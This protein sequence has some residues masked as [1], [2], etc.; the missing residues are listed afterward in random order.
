MSELRRRLRVVDPNLK[1]IPGGSRRHQHRANKEDWENASGVICRNCNREVFR[2]R[3]G[4][5]MSCWE[6]ENE[7][8]VRDK[9]GITSWLPMDIL[10]QITHP[11]R[12]N[13]Q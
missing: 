1:I 8:E 6:E 7:I 9:S 2:S 5:C 10:K 13:Q 4:L 3:D 11:S 12:K